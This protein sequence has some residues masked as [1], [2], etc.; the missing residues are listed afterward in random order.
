MEKQTGKEVICVLLRGLTR[1]FLLSLLLLAS[2]DLHSRHPRPWPCSLQRI[3]RNWP[4]ER[5][6]ERRPTGLSISLA[7]LNAALEKLASGRRWRLWRR[8]KGRQ[9]TSSQVGGG[10]RTMKEIW[11]T[12]AMLHALPPRPSSRSLQ[13]SG[14]NRSA[15][16]LA[17]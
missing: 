5:R 10:S 15:S 8:N 17:G 16:P 9:S 1:I 7:L 2:P 3:G 6:G 12:L 13:A 4:V 11:K 14:G